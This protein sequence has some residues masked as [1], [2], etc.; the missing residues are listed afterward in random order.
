MTPKEQLFWD[1]LTKVLNLSQH[2][3]IKLQVF[4]ATVVNA[5]YKKLQQQTKVHDKIKWLIRE[6]DIQC[7]SD[8]RPVQWHKYY[9][10]LRT[11]GINQNS[12]LTNQEQIDFLDFSKPIIKEQEVYSTRDL[13]KYKI[14]PT[15]ETVKK[16][17][18]AIGHIM[19]PEI[20]IEIN[21]WIESQPENDIL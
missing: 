5:C 20:L 11:L 17:L 4:P 2:G 18:I 16:G 6:C 19:S 13:S 14:V 3:L 9:D 12:S 10:S 15:L 8:G 7:K 21:K 1:G